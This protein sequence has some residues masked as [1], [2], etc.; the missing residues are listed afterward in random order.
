MKHLALFV[1]ILMALSLTACVPAAHAQ[2]ESALEGLWADGG[3]NLTLDFQTPGVV[4]LVSKNYPEEDSLLPYEASEGQL[5]LH[6]PDST[7]TLQCT[8]DNGTSMLLFWPDGR[9]AVLGRVDVGADAAGE[10]DAAQNA[11]NTPTFPHQDAEERYQAVKL[12]PLPRD[13][14]SDIQ[15]VEDGSGRLHAVYVDEGGGISAQMLDQGEWSGQE[16]VLAKEDGAYID[17]FF[18]TLTSEGEPAVVCSLDRNRYELIRFD[19]QKWSRDPQPALK[20]KD[21]EIAGNFLWACFW[22]GKLLLAADVIGATGIST[23]YLNGEPLPGN[24]GGGGAQSGSG[25]DLALNAFSLDN[26]GILYLDSLGEAGVMDDAVNSAQRVQT[27]LCETRYSV[28]GGKTWQGPVPVVSPLGAPTHRG[29]AALLEGRL[30]MIYD[31]WADSIQTGRLWLATVDK[32]NVSGVTN[33]LDNAKLTGSNYAAPSFRE[34]GSDAS[35]T[36][37]F[38]ADG[39]GLDGFQ[40]VNHITLQGDG[41]WRVALTDIPYYKADHMLVL[42]DGRAVFYGKDGLEE[43]DACYVVYGLQ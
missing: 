33:C 15:M 9:M 24:P 27:F 32:E 36:P 11:A 14:S 6:Y 8:I 31:E 22:Q 30:M 41:T 10:T 23:L 17:Q 40:S 21:G 19:G 39:A 43:S 7:V 25:L 5:V 16:V 3:S 34:I 29:S 2:A 20:L 12:A 38:L 1:G 28:D 35:G 42:R 37:H 26:Q 13:Y 4:H 18:L